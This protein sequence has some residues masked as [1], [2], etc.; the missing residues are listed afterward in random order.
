MYE[1]LHMDLSSVFVWFQFE[2]QASAI[3]IILIT[4][5]RNQQWPWTGNGDFYIERYWFDILISPISIYW[6]TNRIMQ[7]YDASA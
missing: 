4:H 3:L 7:Q 2:N 6:G 1:Q 5:N